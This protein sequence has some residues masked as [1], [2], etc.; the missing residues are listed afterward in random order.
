[1]VNHFKKSKWPY[2][3]LRLIIL[4]IGLFP[5]FFIIYAFFS[6]APP[7][8]LCIVIA[9][10]SPICISVALFSSDGEIDRIIGGI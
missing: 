10:V 2:K 6:A 1:M 3:I 9:V 7:F 5:V 4:V 8:W